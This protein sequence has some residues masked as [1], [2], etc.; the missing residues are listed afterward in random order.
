MRSTRNSKYKTHR[1]KRLSATY[2]ASMS[3]LLRHHMGGLVVLEVALSANFAKPR[4]QARLLSV[5]NLYDMP[6]L[7]KRHNPYPKPST[8]DRL[9]LEM[10]PDKNLAGRD[11]P[12][13]RHAGLD[14][15]VILLAESSS[16]GLARCRTQADP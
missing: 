6:Q 9:L 13:E 10:L 7:R 1:I 15:G 2:S 14:P 5:E 3:L 8:L 16:T 4:R 11:R 12:V